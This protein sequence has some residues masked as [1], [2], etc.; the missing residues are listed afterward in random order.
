MQLSNMKVGFI[1][2]GNMAT[3]IMN[4]LLK[5]SMVDKSN[6]Y[7]SDMDIGKLSILQNEGVNT[8]TNNKITV[9]NSDIII[10][11]V[12]PNIY[13]IVLKELSTI[14]SIH[15][16]V[17]VSIAA[18]ISIKY[19][20]SFFDTEVKIVRTMPNTP[21]LIGEGM[22]VLTYEHPVTKNEFEL[23]NDIFKS[24]GKVEFISENYMNE[25]VAVNG[26]SPA[27]VYMMI[28][29]MA[30]AAVMRGIPR[31]MAYN[32]AAQSVAGAAKMVIE[33]GK[34]PG[35]LKDTVCSPGGTTIQAVYQLEKSG[36]RSSLMDAMEKCTEK[37]IELGK[38]YS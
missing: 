26:S 14:V 27:Y 21:A 3:A 28:E 25:V 33:T 12:K 5:A 24:I 38:K 37:A 8:S 4:G 34:H 13:G 23:V 18:G 16:K 10:L 19:I 2:A 36:F 35:E 7:V 1:G 6:I 30:D 11:A 31:N 29:A 15:N 20:K 22:T 17:I 32:L 9:E